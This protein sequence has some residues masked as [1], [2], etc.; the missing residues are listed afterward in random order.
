[1]P[2]S[3]STALVKSLAGQRFLVYGIVL[4]AVLA[5]A[6]SPP[7][8]P[9]PAPK[10]LVVA[11]DGVRPD[12][13]AA[14]NTPTIYALIAGG[15]YS[16][17]AHGEDLTY[18]APNWSTIL[19]GVHRDKHE[20]LDNE[21][22]ETNLDSW[23]DFFTYLERHNPDWNTY[24]VMTWKE[25]HEGQPTGADFAIFRDYQE[26]G[27]DLAS[28]DIAMLLAGTHPEYPDDPDAIFIFYSDTD[29]AGT[30]S[31]SS[32]P[33]PTWPATSSASIPT[34]PGISP[35]LKR[36]MASSAASSRRSMNGAPTV[37]RIGW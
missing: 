37:K 33:T 24:R 19:H 4:T 13:L 6:C 25:A 15:S 9:E 23:P 35:P 27:D 14:A 31:S 7:P 26:Q 30:R 28:E 8:S 21:Y 3:T 20:S 16:D 11:I 36:S 1:M 10:V 32:I 22:P 29:V 34:H 2:N 5:A 17:S 18:S 12:A